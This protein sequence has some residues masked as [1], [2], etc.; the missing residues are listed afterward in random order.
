MVD[1]FSAKQRS[2]IMSRVKSRGN[3]ATEL[4]LMRLFREF[5]FRGWRRSAS[6]FGSPDFIFPAVRVAVFVDGCFWHGCPT[7]GSVP[8]TNWK[9]WR[10]KLSRNKRRDKVVGAKLKNS[11]WHVI[12][13]WQHELREPDKVA[14]RIGRLLIRNSA[15]AGGE[16]G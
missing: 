4:R 16:S 10:R 15:R 14:R 9:F 13:I 2:E 12:R 5:Q 8:G 3:Q 6:I 1:M 11:G 7:H